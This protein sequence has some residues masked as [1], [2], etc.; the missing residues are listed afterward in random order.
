M[1][2]VYEIRWDKS[3]IELAGDVQFHKEIGMKII[4]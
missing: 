1:L 4:G 3:G 2:G